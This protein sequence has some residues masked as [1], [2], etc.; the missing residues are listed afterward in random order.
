M[1]ASNFDALEDGDTAV[2]M[3]TLG[4]IACV[5]RTAQLSKET[6]IT[7]EGLYKTFSPIGNPSFDMV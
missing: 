6:D 4:D 5:R 1:S 3:I 2:V 7:C